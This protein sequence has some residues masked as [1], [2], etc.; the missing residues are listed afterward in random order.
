MYQ[1]S[2]NFK[3]INAFKVYTVNGKQAYV[4]TVCVRILSSSTC[5]EILCNYN[6]ESA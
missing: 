3:R 6:V 4:K 2:I 1:D 5:S